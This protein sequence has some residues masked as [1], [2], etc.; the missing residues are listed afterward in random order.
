MKWKLVVG[1]VLMVLLVASVSAIKAKDSVGT[2]TDVN[3]ITTKNSPGHVVG[4]GCKDSVVCNDIDVVWRYVRDSL[5]E[6]KGISFDNVNVVTKETVVSEDEQ[7][8]EANLDRESTKD[9][10]VEEDPADEEVPAE[11]P[12]EDPAE[13][14]K[15]VETSTVFVPTL[16]ESD[17]TIDDSV[18]FILDNT[19]PIEENIKIA[20]KDLSDISASCCGDWLAKLYKYLG[21]NY[22]Y[23]RPE[24]GDTYYHSLQELANNHP[25]PIGYGDDRGAEDHALLLLGFGPDMNSWLSDF[26]YISVFDGG[27]NLINDDSLKIVGNDK[28]LVISYGS[29]HK[30]HFNIYP[31]NTYGANIK[32]V[33]PWK[34]LCNYEY[35][36]TTRRWE[37][38]Q[39]NPSWSVYNNDPALS[40]FYPY[41]GNCDNFKI[42]GSTT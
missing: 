29:D 16:S 2:K 25:L 17:T 22:R 23:Y 14:E 13:E 19:P 1:I 33:H 5:K 31:K 40:P 9:L 8:K 37:K 38:D 41:N 35:N 18:K 36:P 39:A 42:I 30:V 11:E 15:P 21:Y 27:G 26:S 10:P 32:I 34:H 7:K 28:A 6:S 24:T 4:V 12:T 20:I 3:G